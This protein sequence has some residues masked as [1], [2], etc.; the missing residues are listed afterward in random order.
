MFLE[1]GSVPSGC[2]AL[3]H[4][5]PHNETTFSH[6]TPAAPVYESTRKHQLHHSCVSSI[7]KRGWSLTF[8]SVKGLKARERLLIGI[9]RSKLYHEVVV[10]GDVCLV[11][12]SFFSVCAIL[13]TQRSQGPPPRAQLQ[14]GQTNLPDEHRALLF[15]TCCKLFQWPGKHV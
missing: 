14:N 8:S 15:P 2:H 5:P 10:N 12:W 3:L 7:C 4:L 6:C 13:S 11:A 1:A 9:I